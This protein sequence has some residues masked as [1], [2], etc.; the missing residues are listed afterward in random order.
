M[1]AACGIHAIEQADIEHYPAGIIAD[2]V[3]V[4]VSAGANGRPQPGLDGSLKGLGGIV[5]RLTDLDAAH[6]FCLRGRKAQVMAL[7]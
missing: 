6:R 5:R 7:P 4:A 1:S 2:E 3:F